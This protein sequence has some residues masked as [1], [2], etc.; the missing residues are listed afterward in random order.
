MK[1]VKYVLIGIVIL[2][3]LG[4]IFKPKKKE[5]EAV[6]IKI[7]E[8]KKVKQ[9]EKIIDLDNSKFWND[10]DPLVKTRIYKMIEEKDC[11]GL[12]K[13][14]NIT[15]DNMDRLQASGNS[16]SRNLD[17]MKFLEEKIKELDC[18]K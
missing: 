15:A 3:V 17:L 1:N 18:Y 12:Q 6:K 9:E 10:F 14:F 11:S 13:E 2:G 4:N 8:A 16:G 5:I 7:E